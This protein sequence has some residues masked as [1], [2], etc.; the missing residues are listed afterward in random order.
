MNEVETIGDKFTPEMLFELSSLYFEKE[1]YVAWEMKVTKNLGLH[2]Y[3]TPLDLIDTFISTFPF[4]LPVRQIL[5]D[6][7][8]LACVH[9]SACEFTS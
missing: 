4:L 7:I 9:P 8:E 2:R 3:T 1:K 6:F 5:P